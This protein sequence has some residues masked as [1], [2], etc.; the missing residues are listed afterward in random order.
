MDKEEA[1]KT[2]DGVRQPVYPEPTRGSLS[3]SHTNYAVQKKWAGGDPD[4][5]MHAYFIGAMIIFG[6]LFILA[7]KSITGT[8]FIF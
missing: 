8:T 5:N 3:D 1:N 4:K 6:V 2:T 7:I